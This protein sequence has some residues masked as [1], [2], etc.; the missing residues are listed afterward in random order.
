LVTFVSTLHAGD[1]PNLIPYR[2]GDKWGYCDPQKK[3]IIPLLYDRTYPFC[4]G[5][6]GVQKGRVFG[7]GIARVS[8]GGKYG[9][10]DPAGKEVVPIKYDMAGPVDNGLIFVRL[11]NKVGHVDVHGREYFEE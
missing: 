7:G 10:L 2:K 5:L 4:D 6:G 1:V 11:G 9:L 3:I 8:R